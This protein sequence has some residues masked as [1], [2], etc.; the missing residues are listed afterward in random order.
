VNVGVHRGRR[1]ARCNMQSHAT[2]FTGIHS[3]RSFF[4]VPSSEHTQFLM[5]TQSNTHETN[6]GLKAGERGMGMQL[7]R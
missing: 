7:C 3:C 5:N 6:S 4:G 2:V 1:G